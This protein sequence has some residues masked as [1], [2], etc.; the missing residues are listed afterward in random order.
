MDSLIKVS[1][2][3]KDHAHRR[4]AAQKKGGKTT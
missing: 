2:D 3:R 4:V 1:Y